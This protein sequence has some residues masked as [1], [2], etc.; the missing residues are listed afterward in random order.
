[1]LI[2]SNRPFQDG[3]NRE[4]I[5]PEE[6]GPLKVSGKRNEGRLK[7]MAR[8][9]SVSLSLSHPPL[10]S[11]PSDCISLPLS[12]SLSWAWAVWSW[13]SSRLHETP[14]HSHTPVSQR[15]IIY[16][17]G[18]SRS[19]AHTHTHQIIISEAGQCSSNVHL[20]VNQRKYF[21]KACQMDPW[22]VLLRYHPLAAFSPAALI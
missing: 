2:R 1:M 16:F 9:P 18:V 22:Y 5:V 14:L 8:L 4:T 7:Q 15:V 11:S 19:V 13:G 21:F 3:G 20:S 12:L 17:Q 10:C 6:C